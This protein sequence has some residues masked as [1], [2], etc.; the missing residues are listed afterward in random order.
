MTE[1]IPNDHENKHKNCN[2][3]SNDESNDGLDEPASVYQQFGSLFQKI[4]RELHSGLKNTE[5]MNLA[6]KQWEI[7]RISGLITSDRKKCT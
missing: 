2:H 5:Y 1:F 4:Q 6:S 7:L 3:E